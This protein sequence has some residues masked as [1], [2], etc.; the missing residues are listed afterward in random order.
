VAP[1]D[2]VSRGQAL[3][4]A[5]QYQEAVKICRLGL[6]GK[7]TAVDG[8]VVL[9]QALLALR[10]Y[11][12]VLAEMRVALELD[13]TSAAAYQLKGEALLRKGDAVAATETLTRAKQLAPG[14]PSIAALHAEAEIAKD[15]TSA[16]AFGGYVDL[17][18]SM[19]KHY[20][21]HSGEDG[22]GQRSTSHTRPTSLAKPPTPGRAR[23]DDFHAPEPSTTEASPAARRSSQRDIQRE[24]P[25][26]PRDLTRDPSPRAEPPRR[27]NDAT[28]PP[29]VLS[30]GDRS[31]TVEVDPERDGVEVNDDFG[32]LADP[33]EPTSPEP[34]RPAPRKLPAPKPARAKAP[35][36]QPLPS[37]AEVLASSKARHTP[38]IQLADDDDVVE[39][40]GVQLIETPAPELVAPVAR[41]S[42]RP[43]ATA[44][45][46]PPYNDA[47]RAASAARAV[48]MAAG[49]L[50]EPPILPRVSAAQ[51]EAANRPTAIEEAMPSSLRPPNLSPLPPGLP[52]PNA[53]RPPMASA[54]PTVAG[55]AFPPPAGLPPPRPAPP[56]PAPSGPAAAAMPTLALNVAQQRSAAA[57]DSL[58]PDEQVAVGAP[59]PTWAK[60]TVVAPG[61][62]GGVLPAVPPGAMG[63]GAAPPGARTAR[64]GPAVE[65]P[66]DSSPFGN[67]L[68]PT[69]PPG[70]VPGVPEGVRHPR[71]GVRGPRQL[72][73]ALWI[74]LG[75]VVIGGGVFAG[76]QIRRMRLEKQ[77]GEAIKNA[78]E[79]ARPDTWLGWIKARNGF[80]NIVDAQ[81]SDEGRARVARARAVLAADYG[82]DTAGAIK[83][84][85]ALGASGGGSDGA[86]ARA[87]LALAAGDPQIAVP[88]AA[89]AEKATGDAIG[90]ALVG[91]A[92]LLARRPGEAIAALALAVEKDPRPAHLVAL[93]E[94]EL[95]RGK[96]DDAKAACDKAIEKVADHPA[97]LIVRARVLAA[98]GA[99]ATG[100]LGAEVQGQLERVLAEG[101]RPP[102]SQT[103]G[104]SPR[105]AA[106]AGLAL[107]TVHLARGD[108]QAARLAF[109]RVTVNRPD[110]QRFAEQVVRALR[111]LGQYTQ[112]RAEAQR[113]SEKW[114]A[115]AGLRVALA[116]IQLAEGDGTAALDTLAAG[117]GAVT[118]PEGLTLRARAHLARGDL[119]AARKDL[120]TALAAAADYEPAIVARTWVDLRG[121]EG[122]QAL[123]RI[124][125]VYTAR[126]LDPAVATAYAAALRQTGVRDKAREV[127]L[128][129]TAGPEGPE[130]A[131]AWLE[132]GR[133]ERDLGDY[134]AARKAYSKAIAGRG[135]EAK[136]EA[137]LLY[138]DDADVAGGSQ[139]LEALVKDAPSDG[140]VL[141]EAA[142]VRTL[143]GEL[144]GA[145]ELLDRAAKL[146][147][148]PA[149]DLAR[150]RGRLAIKAAAF[151][152]AIAAFQTAIE[153]NDVD[154]EAHLLLL[155]AISTLEDA[156]KKATELLEPAKKRFGDKPER[157]LIMGKVAL[158]NQQ[159]TQARAYFNNGMHELELKKAPRRRIAEAQFG[160]GWCAVATND[161]ATAVAFF[162]EGLRRD[163]TATDVWIALGDIAST[164]GKTRRALDR[165]QNAAK[166]NPEYADLQFKVGTA[167]AAVGE[168]VI[169]REA[170]DKYLQLAPSG[171]YA[172]QA[173]QLRGQL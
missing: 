56:M 120:E 66:V 11:D 139:T 4:A 35:S 2:F 137:A 144:A 148:A 89:A 36:R 94:A 145:R 129:V 49:P 15:G 111:R 163:P 51:L 155:D 54:L 154:F 59:M 105:Q 45:P 97:A 110:D 118:E 170:L 47:A 162:D 142:R 41:G 12:E 63:P 98:S 150:E 88:A 52:A 93:A 135:I 18:D 124:E 169:A 13:N 38:S 132:L 72:R 131:V 165:F 106:D 138:I 37:P 140:R 172:A 78:E 95:A 82:D 68:I 74:A 29:N 9:G 39:L 146:D 108:A 113:A 31:G 136:L 84:V 166:Y 17:G 119:Q 92:A 58:F 3:V 171:E 6:L 62:Q 116:E 61:V 32:D 107:V 85:E 125:P 151:P 123:A 21:S 158:I 143:L 5:G 80:I 75:A 19:T 26:E 91:R 65:P 27:P 117:G 60:S 10:R 40:S 23:P 8:R 102:A 79:D 81:D 83:A 101:A 121:G 96:L 128:E 73:I 76:F 147:S 28:P 53:P 173:R 43:P 64:P 160:L 70:P 1:S 153:K 130:L 24:V 126:K 20:P 50:P 141:I 152:E 86:I 55:Q 164:Q 46:E 103:V 104:V 99:L 48:G 14:D 7:P 87:Y 157:F 133:L 34:T 127:L 90:H 69:P 149:G 156:T 25:P 115:S 100:T 22:S 159:L 168:A 112:A 30:V 42:K 44:Q 16:G 71:T 114:P 122:A 109:E 67:L 33:P 167:A 77:I 134:A 161:F 57:V